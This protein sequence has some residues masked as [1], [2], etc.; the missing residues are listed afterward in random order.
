MSVQVVAG[1]REGQGAGRRLRHDAGMA[2]ALSSLLGA[3]I[4][5]SSCCWGTGCVGE[6]SERRQDDVSSL[7]PLWLSVAL[8][9]TYNR[10]GGAL[11]DSRE[12]HQPRTDALF[13]S[14]ERYEIQT[15]F[16]STPG[17]AAM[18][19]EASKLSSTWAALVTSYD[20]D[21]AWREAC[22]AHIR[23]LREFEAATRRQMGDAT[24]L[25]NP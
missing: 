15:R 8:A 9:A 12:R 19:P 16:W 11:I 18:S 20:D 10:I 22:T 25:P 2:S 24:P 23:A 7:K 13:P 17:C 3:V 5:V 4:G 6:P 1:V 21:D 14:V